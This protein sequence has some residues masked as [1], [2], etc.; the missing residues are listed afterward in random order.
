MLTAFINFFYSFFGLTYVDA[1]PIDITEGNWT[2][3]KGD[4]LDWATPQYD[5]THW[6]PIEVGK[7]WEVVAAGY[8]GFGWYRKTIV[9]NSKQMR[10]AVRCKGQLVIRLGKIDDADETFL[11]V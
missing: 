1:Q 10:R 2:F 7:P 4:S 5:A 3:Q 11:M 8:D 9:L 6:Q